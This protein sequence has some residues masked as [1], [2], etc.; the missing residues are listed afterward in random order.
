[1]SNDQPDDAPELS[2]TEDRIEGYNNKVIETSETDTP[3]FEEANDDAERLSRNLSSNNPSDLPEETD[4][5]FGIV[6]ENVYEEP[7][8]EHTLDR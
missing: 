2:T 7:F 1:M 6:E 8:I 5:E 4:N 3:T